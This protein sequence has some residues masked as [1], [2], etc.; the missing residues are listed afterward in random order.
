M[1]KIS[2]HN[3]NG[4]N[5]RLENQ[6]KK[7][8]VKLYKIIEKEGIDYTNLYIL[9]TEDGNGKT[10]CSL[11]LRATKDSTLEDGLVQSEVEADGFGIIRGK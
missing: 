6:L 1:K 5:I 4:K 9:K 8:L 2:W 10:L 3:L 7:L 11:N